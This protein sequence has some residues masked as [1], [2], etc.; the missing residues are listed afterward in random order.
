MKEIEA[1]VFL[2]VWLFLHYFIVL[3]TLLDQLASLQYFA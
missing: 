2:F 3:L 1:I